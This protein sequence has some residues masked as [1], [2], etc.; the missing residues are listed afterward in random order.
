MFKSDLIEIDN[1]MESKVE[2]MKQAK[3]VN[4]AQIYKVQLARICILEALKIELNLTQTES[5]HNGT[6]E[7]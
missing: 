7:P 1:L 3:E 4:P 6:P 5:M 2:Q